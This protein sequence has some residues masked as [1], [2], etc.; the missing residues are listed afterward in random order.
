[1]DSLCGSRSE[2]VKVYTLVGI[3]HYVPLEEPNVQVFLSKQAA[4]QALQDHLQNDTENMWA[5]W[6]DKHVVG[7]Q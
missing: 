7:V 2:C 4:E 1:M 6:L 5:W 3:C